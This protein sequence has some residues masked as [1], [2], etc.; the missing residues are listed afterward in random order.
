MLPFPVSF[1]TG[2]STGPHGRRSRQKSEIR[3]WTALW[4]WWWNNPAKNFSR[5]FEKKLCEADKYCDSSEIA[6]ILCTGYGYNILAFHMSTKCD[7]EGITLTQ[8][9]TLSLENFLDVGISHL[10]VDWDGYHIFPS[11][12]PSL[13]QIIRSTKKFDRTKIKGIHKYPASSNLSQWTL[14][15]LPLTERSQ[16]L[17][18]FSRLPLQL[19]HCS[20]LPEYNERWIW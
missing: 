12:E 1:L 10:K 18:T 15:G 8:K 9:F 16:L 3:K 6:E 7:F 4:S 17:L 13:E 5:K 20:A 14:P 19:G 2:A 11:P